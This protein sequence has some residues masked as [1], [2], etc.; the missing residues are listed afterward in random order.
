MA[1]QYLIEALTEPYFSLDQELE[2]IDRLTFG[3][4][5]FFF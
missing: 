5:L 3:A 2:A 1:R 4:P